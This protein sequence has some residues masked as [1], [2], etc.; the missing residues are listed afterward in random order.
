MVD[1]V[2]ICNAA[3]ALLGDDKIDALTDT[4]DRAK[5]CARLYD[6]VRDSVLRAH[7]W[8]CCK[9]RAVLSPTVTA[10]A[11]E[12]SYQFLMPSDCIRVISIAQEGYTEP[13]KVEGR[14][15]LANT[16]V[17]NCRYIFN[18]DDP[19]SYSG[20]LVDVMVYSMAKAL[21][22]PITHSASMR[23]EMQ[24]EYTRALVQARAADG[25]E[26]YTE[27]FNQGPVKVSRFMP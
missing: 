21:A 13:Y 12:W 15:I 2:G 10:P 20:G 16:N 6:S 27:L 1:K 18:N 7:L 24:S 19:T 23:G 4:T 11:F 3:L 14:M 8:K 26:D 5:L 17:A 25:Q 9:K 22:Y